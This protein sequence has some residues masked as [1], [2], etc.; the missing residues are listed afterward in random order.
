MANRWGNNGN[1]D[2]LFSWAPKSLQMVTAAMK[3]KDT[4]WEKSYDKP[5]QHI[6]KQRHY[7]A[8]K[9]L[10]SQ[11]C[12]FSSTHVQMWDLDHNEGWVPKNWYSQTVVLKKT[13]ECPLECKE[14]KPVHPKGNQSWIFVGRTDAETEVPILWPPDVKDWLIGKDS[15]AGKD[16]GQKEK[17]MT[18]DEMAG[19][20]HRL[21]GHG[22]G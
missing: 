4:S 17:G 5:R 20:H 6:K 3:L 15:N 10:S 21:D 18:E 2:G 8:N 1:S 7:F 19:W 16:W 11:S 13:L 9:G 14:I 12:G 22:F